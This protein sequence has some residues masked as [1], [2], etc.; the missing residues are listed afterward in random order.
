MFGQNDMNPAQLCYFL[1]RGNNTRAGE[2]SNLN[3]EGVSVNA[4]PTLCQRRGKQAEPDTKHVG[5]SPAEQPIS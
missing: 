3:T 4:G 5:N 1:G 2:N